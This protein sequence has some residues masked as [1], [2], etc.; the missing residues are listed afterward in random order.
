MK[1]K[2]FVTRLLPKEA[3]DR[4]HSNCEATVWDG[5]LPPPREVLLKNVVDVE[6]L[7]SLLTDKIDAELMDKAPKLKV[8]S[9]YAVGFDNVDIP[10]ATKR[11]IIV[12]N[13]PGVLTD[14]TAD[15]AF[16]LIMSAARR[17]AEGDRYVRAGKW[18]TWGPMLLLGQDVYGSTL[19]I[20]GLGR[21]GAALARR[22]KGFN[23]R[24][25]YYDVIRQKQYE[26]ELGI[27]YAT[28]DKV[29]TESDF[30]TIHTNLTPE[31]HHLISTKQFEKM[32][33]TCILVNTSRG[34][35]V[36]NMALYEALRTGK[37]LYAGLDVTEPEPLPAN[38]PLLT[39]DNVI[40]APHI[41]SASVVT[42]TKMGLI[43]ADNL[44]A[45]LKGQLGP[46]PV[47]PEVLKKR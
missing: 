47:N 34:P 46:A 40:I 11:G 8:V 15:F 7:L 22:A 10:E 37:I 28:L 23:M 27:E 14:T 19:G 45:G 4:I 17:V 35:I 38:H 18:K 29:L 43:A 36:D 24:T 42:R 20:I 44:I 5:E 1:P 39:L 41:A 21:I 3:M 16:T 13:T 31:T 26:D 2:V 6:G 32:K 33:R 25:M 12:G 9:N 30:I